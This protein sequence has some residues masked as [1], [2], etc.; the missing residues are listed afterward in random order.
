M[1]TLKVNTIN[2]STTGQAVDVDIKFKEPPDTAVGKAVIADN[3]L[4]FANTTDIR[5]PH[6]LL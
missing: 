3:E 5:Q 2:A 1:S 6:T 4:L